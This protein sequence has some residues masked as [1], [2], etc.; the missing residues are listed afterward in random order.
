V[1]VLVPALSFLLVWLDPRALKYTLLLLRTASM[2]TST[3]APSRKRTRSA[4][5]S[6]Q[7]VAWRTAEEFQR[8]GAALVSAARLTS[9]DPIP[10]DSTGEDWT[11]LR[12]LAQVQAWKYRVPRLPHAVE[13]SAAL[14]A[15]LWADV[16]GATSPSEQQQ[17][18]RLASANRDISIMMP[19]T[20]YA[21]PSNTLQ[22]A[23][24]AAIVRAVNGLVDRMQ[25][26]RSVA[27]SIAHHA[28]GLGLPPWLV[29]IRHEATHNALPTL[30][31]LRLGA[32]TLLDYFEAV[33]WEPL[34]RA[35]QQER[36]QVY[37]L[38]DA[39]QRRVDD[40][41]WLVTGSGGTNDSDSANNGRKG[42]RSRQ[43]SLAPSLRHGPSV[44]AAAGNGASRPTLVQDDAPLDWI[45]LP[46]APDESPVV[47]LPDSPILPSRLG[48][49]ANMFALL[50]EAPKRK[51]TGK[52]SAKK[53]KKA[54][55]KAA[56]TPSC[57]KVVPPPWSALTALAK[58][59]VRAPLPLP[60]VWE[61]VLE[62]LVWGRQQ[63]GSTDARYDTLP[64][65][66]LFTAS[67]AH[68]AAAQ[69]GYHP[70]LARLG[71][72]TP[73]LWQAL[74]I[75]LVDCILQTA[76]A[77]FTSATRR[78]ASVEDQETTGRT[79]SIV[80]T[81]SAWVRHLLSRP[82]VVAVHHAATLAD[83]NVDAPAAPWE[84]IDESWPL[85]SL[86][87]RCEQ[88]VL[89]TSERPPTNDGARG[90][91]QAA[92]AAA[93]ETAIQSLGTFLSDLLDSHR[94]ADHGIV[95]SDFEATSMAVVQEA[96]LPT[97]LLE[98][99]ANAS[100]SMSL[101]DMEAM[102]AGKEVGTPTTKT[103]TPDTSTTEVLSPRSFSCTTTTWAR[104]TSWDACP[105]GS[106]PGHPP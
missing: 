66:V 20:S 1:A 94:V 96:P 57:K 15:V 24:A 59:I 8:V 81:G 71:R 85:N 68:R 89:S 50:M 16:R 18:S 54:K 39:Y 7:C 79:L 106:L 73:G 48:T 92:A 51:K 93:M 95:E 86:C 25:Q 12:A 30:A 53:P 29:D 60:Q 69:Q 97:S 80:T 40:F 75:N 101:E 36:H 84:L 42:E 34:A 105:I 9:Y 64:C 56:P 41:F 76:A 52:T 3:A 22:L 33:Y 62:H 55:V 87:D 37:D 32:T 10:T 27:T 49:N 63:L 104:C 4:Q 72:E 100:A 99:T 58:H 5:A 11:I 77:S 14:A 103:V 65:G 21:L 91:S 13:S 98:S 90:R 2:A 43:G 44:A 28:A 19:T 45:P 88:F 83:N 31:V 26:T 35:R 78:E 82:F 17:S 46:T 38:L 47:A 102:L 23:Y 61:A 74:V 6:F 70:L 67:A